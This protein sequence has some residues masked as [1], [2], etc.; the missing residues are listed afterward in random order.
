MNL[1]VHA[2]SAM[3]FRRLRPGEEIRARFSQFHVVSLIGIHLEPGALVDQVFEFGASRARV[4]ISK[5]VNGACRHMAADDYTDDEAEWSRKHSCQG[6]YMLVLFGPTDERAC[7]AGYVKD[8]GDGTVTTYN[9]FSSAREELS[10]LADGALGSVLAAAT[11]MLLSVAETVSI[12]QVD[13]LFVGVTPQGRVLHDMRVTAS[14]H[15]HAT[16]S[17]ESE[18]VQ[19]QLSFA[20]SLAGRLDP[21]VARFFRLGASESD[22]LRK[23]LYFFLAIEVE[24]HAAFKRVDYKHF[25]RSVPRP[26]PRAPRAASVFLKEPPEEVKSLKGRFVCCVLGPWIEL[27]DKHVDEFVRLKTIRDEIAHGVLFD[28]P[29][30]AAR[31]AELLAL[32]VLRSRA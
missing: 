22:Q 23:F 13:R 25:L 12:K 17:V 30:G 7:S 18:V 5:T 2:L 16:Q 28:P 19:R 15:G 11:A 9:C 10:A 1:S 20:A 26:H 8:D 21:K 14:A 29:A 4:A 24:T 27:D 3:G 6:P 31:A 32:I